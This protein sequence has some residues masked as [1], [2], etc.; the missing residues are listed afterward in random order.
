MIGREAPI[1][2]KIVDYLQ[3]LGWHYKSR[4]QI[5][6]M[7]AGRMGEALVEPLLVDSLCKLN[8]ISEQA[9]LQVVERLRRVVDSE[10]FLEILRDGIS[11]SFRA[12]EKARRLIVVDW[13]NPELNTFIV[14]TEYEL[15]T[16]ALREP[17]LDVVCLVNGIPL[18]LV[19]TK[20]ATVSWKKAVGDFQQYWTD[21]PELERFA[22]VCV[23]TNGFTFRCAPSGALK[24]SQYAEWK[25]PWP[26]TVADETRD[27]EIGLLGVF[28][29]GHLV[30]IAA[31][32]L[33]FET[34]K[35][36][37]TKKLARYQQFRAANKIVQ[38][39]LDGTHNR[40]IV[41]HTQGSG[42]SLTMLFA[43]RKLR[44]VGLG[45]PTVLIVIDRVDLDDQINETFSAASF[46]GV[47]R[48]ETRS[49]LHNLLTSDRRGVI[50]T[51]VEKFDESMHELVTRENVIVFVD[52]AHRTQ[53][54]LFGIRM[55]AALPKAKLFAFTGTPIETQDRS[56]RRAFSPE[57]NGIY[58]EYLD[59]YSPRQA[60]EDGATVEVRYEYRGDDWGFDGDELNA[61]FEAFAELEGLTD[62]EQERIKA[63]A[64]RL[65][66]VA[67]APERVDAIAEDIA[68]Y[69]RK[70]TEPQGFKA[71]LVAI[72]R[73]ACTLYADALIRHGLHPEELAVIYTRDPKGDTKNYRRWYASEQW[74]RHQAAGVGSPN[75]VPPS[76]RQHDISESQAK[77]KLIEGFKSP[78]S[79]VKVLIVCDML[80]TGFDAPIEQ[81]MFLDKPLR[82]AKLLQAVMRTNRP[83][84]GKDRGIVVDYANVFSKLQQ[85]FAEFSPNEIELA[86]LDLTALRATFPVRIAEA[87][88]LLAGMPDG[89][90]EY[91]QMMWLVH[92]FNEDVDAAT[93]F[94]ERFRLAQSAYEA[95][96]PDP[97]LAGH[98]ADYSR[99]VRMRALWRHGARLGDED[100]YDLDEYRTHTRAL[101]QEAVS[102][103]RLRREAPVYRIDGNFVRNLQ[104]RGG[105]PEERIAAVESAIEFEVRERGESDP[106]AR[107]LAERLERLRRKR[108]ESTQSTLELL[109]N[110]LRL[111][112]DW[113][114]E[115]AG[116]ASHGLS[117]RA[118]GFVSVA[119]AAAGDELSESQLL[120]LARRI[121]AV[122]THNASFP[123]WRDRDDVLRAIR[124]ATINLLLSEPSA[125]KLVSTSFVD[126]VVAVAVAVGR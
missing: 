105:T 52:E 93:V 97:L 44:N 31:N 30:D 49:G 9:A 107:S 18:G 115:R 123:G 65:S 1:Q 8:G 29:P 14:T 13:Q 36:A 86:V 16:G 91:E 27:L 126:D 12:D 58:E 89:L 23:A 11:V 40:G 100:G 124:R 5:A 72:D 76:P 50:I 80:L 54:G 81:V 84:P 116:A 45:N 79:P 111:A 87:L 68:A 103:E 95:L 56:T 24:A 33:V 41:W 99:L 120:D 32:F 70:R 102:L 114:T 85:A 6:S 62:S 26:H 98:L 22:A 117:E 10:S 77:R 112:D 38:R 4:Q 19:E 55:R 43:A 109:N 2:A 59:V 28:N 96:A 63:D 73:E 42:K 101:V 34:R 82:G 20:A 7:R 48:A 94:E 110:H 88:A 92:R 47:V 64:A 104:E 83:Y 75:P 90:E 122:V 118:H 46:R 15:R 69:L 66:V 57:I 78:S 53:E 67:K 113:A 3:T 35:G 60:V 17:R 21:A 121:D 108:Q 71:Q 125:R 37:T 51:T 39:V 106:I 61:A 74:R 25:D 119:R